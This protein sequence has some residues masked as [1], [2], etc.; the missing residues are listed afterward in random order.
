MR[1]G[2][3]DAQGRPVY[4]TGTIYIDGNPVA[5]PTREM[6]LAQ[7]Q[8]PFLDGA[9]PPAAKSGTH[10]VRAGW[11]EKRTAIVP[12]WRLVADAR[13]PRRWTPLA[14]KRACGER[15]PAIRAA[16]E[17]EGIYE[18]CVMAQELRENDEAFRKGY[19]WAVQT[20]GK[21]AVDKVLAAAEGR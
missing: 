20:F 5:N 10:Y 19:A 3:L 6:Y 2:T 18:D 16:L 12:R 8:K 14:I 9:R 17:A 11:T 15:W 4:Y 13:P 7:G 21:E 1:Y